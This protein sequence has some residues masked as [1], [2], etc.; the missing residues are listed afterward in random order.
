MLCH[1]SFHVLR[2]LLRNNSSGEAFNDKILREIR[3]FLEAK[4]FIFFNNN[5]GNMVKKRGLSVV[6]REKNCHFE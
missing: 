6:E 5:S 2:T 3:F 4:T 1:I